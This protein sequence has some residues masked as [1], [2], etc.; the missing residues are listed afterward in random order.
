MSGVVYPHFAVHFTLLIGTY[1]YN[2][3]LIGYLNFIIEIIQKKYSL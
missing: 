2:Q 1:N 3:L